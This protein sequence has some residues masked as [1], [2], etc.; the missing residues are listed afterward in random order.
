M[1]DRVHRLAANNDGPALQRIATDAVA[2]MLVHHQCFMQAYRKDLQHIIDCGC[3]NCRNKT[4]PLF[5]SAMT[6]H[7]DAY[8]LSELVKQLHEFNAEYPAPPVEMI[9]EHIEGYKKFRRSLFGDLFDALM[10]E[11][12]G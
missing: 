4:G 12:E 1:H 8:I 11:E 10:D 3:T 5:A 7:Q 9:Q 2:A 6:M